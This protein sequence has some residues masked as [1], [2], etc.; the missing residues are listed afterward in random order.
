MNGE[1][2]TRWT[3]RLAL[4]LYAATL[5]LRLT[6]PR[7]TRTARLLWTAGCILFLIHVIAA[8]HFF[9]QWSHGDAYRETARQTREM[10]GVASGAG[11]YLN[12]LFTLVWAADVAW[13]WRRGADR[14]TRRPQWV[15]VV[16]QSFLFF[17]AFNG[18]VVFEQ[19]AT[20]WVAA[21]VVVVL[22]ILG[23]VRLRKRL[24]DSSGF[25]RQAG[26]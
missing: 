17:M 9:H 5:A 6:D 15:G 7:R 10:T 22:A 19:G 25:P 11:L 26:R 18:T 2:L 23:I 20:R 3:V 16:L 1:A 14:Y 4:L 8:F 12:Y 13:W 24:V 21:G